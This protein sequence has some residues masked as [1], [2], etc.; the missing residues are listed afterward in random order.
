MKFSKGKIGNVNKKLLVGS[1]VL[2]MLVTPLTGCSVGYTN[3]DYSVNEQGV[4]EV[5]GIIDYELLKDYYFLVI[6]NSN[7]NATEFYI[8]ERVTYYRNNRPVGYNYKDVFNNK[9]VFAN[10]N[11]DVEHV[12]EIVFSDS[13]ENYLYA[14]KN[15][16]ANYTK[17]DVEKILEGMKESYLN[18]NNKQ[19]VKEK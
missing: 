9:S 10:E 6:E 3:F 11:K 2:T 5:S 12:R 13:V 4:Y 8:C 19:L 7:Y 14:T 16:K 15:I 1:L 17:E 18:Q